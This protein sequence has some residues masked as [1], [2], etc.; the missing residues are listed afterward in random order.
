MVRTGHCLYALG[1]GTDT[2]LGSRIIPQIFKKVKK[3]LGSNLILFVCVCVVWGQLTDL[4]SLFIFNMEHRTF[5]R[6]T[7]S[8]LASLPGCHASPQSPT[9]SKRVVWPWMAEV[10]MDHTIQVN[11]SCRLKMKILFHRFL[12][13]EDSHG[14]LLSQHLDSCCHSLSIYVQRWLE[15]H[16]H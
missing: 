4:L 1:Q 11:D 10:R 2:H 16:G 15:L 12:E 7:M 5:Q 3:W 14:T 6:G 9:T 13:K 8:V